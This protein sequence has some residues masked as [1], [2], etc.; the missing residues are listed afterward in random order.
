MKYITTIGENQY[1]VEVLE[2]NRVSIDGKI[3]TVDFEN[4]S[5]HPIYS[6][7]VDGES[8]EAFVYNDDEGLQVML[9]GNLYQVNVE[10]EREVRLRQAGGST[11]VDTT[12]FYLKSPMPG[13][14]I[15]VPVKEGQEVSQGEILL[16]LESMKMQNELRC[17]R[18]GTVLRVRVKVGDNVERKQT[19]IDVE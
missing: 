3:M 19:L 1:M 11:V 4:V 8:Y 2:G 18:D 16:V 13:L 10:D 5:G 9:K 7:L 12:E 17:P 14:V 6:L 15:D